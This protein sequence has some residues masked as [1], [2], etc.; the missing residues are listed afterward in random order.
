MESQFKD[1][2]LANFP[3]PLLPNGGVS[4][5]RDYALDWHMLSHLTG[6]ER[7]A[8]EVSKYVSSFLSHRLKAKELTFEGVRERLFSESGFKLVKIWELAAGSSMC[9]CEGVPV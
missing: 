2:R 5:L 7:P 8:G 3:A 1:T 9:I 4:A 6:C